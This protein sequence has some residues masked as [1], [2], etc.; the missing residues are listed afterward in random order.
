M[1]RF[2]PSEAVLSRHQSSFVGDGNPL[3]APARQVF[4]FGSKRSNQSECI[5][6]NRKIVRRKDLFLLNDLSIASD[7]PAI[8][9]GRFPRQICAKSNKSCRRGG[10]EPRLVHVVDLANA[11]IGK[12]GKLA[13]VNPMR[14]CNRSASSH[15]A[16]ASSNR[17]RSVYARLRLIR[18]STFSGLS[19]TA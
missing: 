18:D 1:Q 14:G 10:A 16:T 19:R 8:A 15:A 4:R 11:H 13:E 2:S 3:E 7:G 17:P 5:E 9:R 12:E 6:K